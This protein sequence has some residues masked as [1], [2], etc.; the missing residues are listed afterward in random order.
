MSQIFGGEVGTRGTFDCDNELPNSIEEGLGIL[1]TIV[2]AGT[3]ELLEILGTLGIT[4]LLE[5][6][7][8]F[9]AFETESLSGRW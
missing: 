6:V 4:P 1:E 2:L 7:E 3:L 5:I 9:G 8:S